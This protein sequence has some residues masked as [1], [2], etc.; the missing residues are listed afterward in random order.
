[1]MERF[2]RQ[3]TELSRFNNT[4]KIIFLYY[5]YKLKHSKCHI[6]NYKDKIGV[7]VMLYA[8]V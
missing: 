4:K 3:C 2:S 6:F 7:A 5:V 1:M 8:Y